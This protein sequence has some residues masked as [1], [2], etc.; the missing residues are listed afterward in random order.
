MSDTLKVGVIGVGAIGRHHLRGLADCPEA[1]VVAIADINEATLEAVADEFGIASTTTDYRELLE[2]E[3]LQ[4]VV[5][6][7]P[8]FMHALP[9]MDAAAKGLHVLCEKPMAL[10]ASEARAMVE[11]CDRAGVKL[12]ICH[13]RA[14]FSAVA[15]AAR[16]YVQSGTLGDIYYG[17]CSTFRRRGRPGLDIMPDSKWFLDASQAGG[18]ALFD[19]GCYDLDLFLYLL[20]SPEPEA[21]TAITFR[22]LEVPGEIDFVYDVEEHASLWVRFAGGLAATFEVAWAAN[23][24]GGDGLR[25]FGTKGGLRLNPF[26]VYMQQHGRPVDITPQVRDSGG[27]SNALQRDFV[28][29]CLHDHPPKTPGSDGAKIMEIMTA[30]YQ[31]AELGR[32]VWIGELRG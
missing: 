19:I 23:M 24:D 22:G 12:G 11:A 15:E 29:A 10:S 14:R 25:L 30:A 21:V 5:V 20:G 27:P 2:E 26:T 6:C 1:E 28:S 7:T 3:G 13:A 8:P 17:R 9:T 4:A 31:S 16:Q 32:E 18:G